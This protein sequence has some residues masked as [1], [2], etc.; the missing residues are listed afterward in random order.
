MTARA[1]E[2]MVKQEPPFTV[3]RNISWYDHYGGFSENK[4]E[5]YS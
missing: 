4:R 1:S 3:D 5:N 2:D